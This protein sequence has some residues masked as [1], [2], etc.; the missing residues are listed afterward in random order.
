TARR[1]GLLLELLADDVVAQLDAFVADVHAGTGNQLAD[2]MLAL[3]AER[4]VEDLVAVAGTALAVFGHEWIWLADAVTVR[5]EHSARGRKGCAT[6]TPFSFSINYLSR[7]DRL[8][9]TPFQDLIHEP[10][11]PGLFGALEVV[12]LGVGGDGFD[13]LAGV[14]GQ[15]LVQPLLQRQDLPRMDIDVRR[16]ALEPTERLVDHHPRIGQRVALAGR[17]RGEQERA[18]AGRLADADG[19]HVGLDELHGVVDRHA[20]GD[21]AAGRIDVQADVLLGVFGLEEQHLRDDHVG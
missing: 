15:D 4:A 3:P 20:R 11:F 19:A 9:R 16:L 21:D 10:L 18:H 7:L 13:R 2:L 6:G 12:A 17:A 1:L 8:F 14:P 5:E